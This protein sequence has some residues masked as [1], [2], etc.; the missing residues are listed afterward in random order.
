MSIERICLSMCSYVCMCFRIYINWILYSST[1]SNTI[2]YVIGLRCNVHVYMLA[3][4]F[5]NACVREF[6]RR[7]PRTQRHHTTIAIIHIVRT[8]QFMRGFIYFSHSNWIA[9]IAIAK[10]QNFELI[11]FHTSL[12]F[13][14]SPAFAS[15][16]LWSFSECIWLLFYVK[17]K[18]STKNEIREKD[19]EKTYT[20]ASIKTLTRQ[21]CVFVCVASKTKIY[22]QQCNERSNEINKLIVSKYNFCCCAIRLALNMYA[23]R[24][25]CRWPKC[26]LPPAFAI[27]FYPPRVYVYWHESTHKSKEKKKRKKH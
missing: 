8:I 14:L 21:K 24:V 9:I 26:V 6:R 7:K 19:N 16:R 11:V 15:L 5:I 4:A 22:I 3:C 13:S 23:L 20:H 12:S 27:W 1:Q 2:Q 10:A 18:K 25:E 17:K